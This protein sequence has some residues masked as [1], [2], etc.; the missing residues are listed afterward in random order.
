MSRQQCNLTTKC[1]IS[2]LDINGKT[3]E[4]K[5]KKASE[6]LGYNND[7]SNKKVLKIKLRL[8]NKNKYQT[9]KESN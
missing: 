5:T 3:I 1:E 7:L 8:E 6:N 9:L 4:K 2:N